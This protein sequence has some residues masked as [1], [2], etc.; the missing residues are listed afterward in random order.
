MSMQMNMFK[1]DLQLTVLPRYP[2]KKSNVLHQETPDRFSVS[3]AESLCPGPKPWSCLRTTAFGR[4][5]GHQAEKPLGSL[6]HPKQMFRVAVETNFER[7]GWK[8][9]RCPISGMLWGDGSQLPRCKYSWVPSLVLCFSQGSL[10]A[11]GHQPSGSSGAP[12]LH[13]PL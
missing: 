4:K 12:A 5:W 6:L 10:G 2:W 1:K 3:L 9:I 8:H 7:S 11:Q 13:L